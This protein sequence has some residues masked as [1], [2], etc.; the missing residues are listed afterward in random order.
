MRQRCRGPH[1][2][3]ALLCCCPSLRRCRNRC[4]HHT[5]SWHRQSDSP[6]HTRQPPRRCLPCS[7]PDFWWIAQVMARSME[8]G[9]GGGG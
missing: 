1:Q 3:L 8:G 2:A 7:Q 9:G 6:H 4:Y 5:K